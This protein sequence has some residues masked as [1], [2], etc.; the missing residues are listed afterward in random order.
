M[1][2]AATWIKHNNPPKDL[3]PAGPYGMAICTL[4]ALVFNTGFSTFPFSG[5]MERISSHRICDGAVGE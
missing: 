4:L 1:L 2:A 5:A 3:D